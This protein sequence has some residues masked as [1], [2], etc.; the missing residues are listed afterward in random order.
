MN[1]TEGT[2]STNLGST[3]GTARSNSA[4]ISTADQTAITQN[5]IR[6]RT[7]TSDTVLP[8][9]D[10]G[11]YYSPT[12]EDWT[13][14][15]DDE[16][17]EHALNAYHRFPTEQ[18]WAGL[19]EEAR[20]KS[21]TADTKHARDGLDA[22][23]MTEAG[24]EDS[25]QLPNLR[26]YI[27]ADTTTAFEEIVAQLDPDNRDTIAGRQYAQ[28]VVDWQWMCEASEQLRASGQ[29]YRPRFEEAHRPIDW[30]WTA[31]QEDDTK[32][33]TDSPR[34]EP[35]ATTIAPQSQQTLKPVHH[36]NF[37]G[38]P[39]YERTYTAPAVSFWAAKSE[40]L[41]NRVHHNGSL[42]RSVIS[43]N[44]GK[45]LDPFLAPDF[46][47]QLKATKLKDWA[48]GLVEVV[49][50]TYGTW[51]SDKLE[52][53][54]DQRIADGP[55]SFF[56]CGD[57]NHPP[58]P[59]VI[60]PCDGDV[61]INDDGR[62]HLA[63]VS[64]RRACVGLPSK[65][66]QMEKIEDI[67]AV[68]EYLTSASVK[69][70]YTIPPDAFAALFNKNKS[71][72]SINTL[73]SVHEA[74]IETDKADDLP[75]CAEEPL[76]DENDDTSFSAVSDDERLTPPPVHPQDVFDFI[77]DATLDPLLSS[78]ESS[79]DSDHYE[80]SFS[81]LDTNSTGSSVSGGMGESY[82]PENL[83][84]DSVPNIASF[85]QPSRAKINKGICTADAMQLDN[86]ITQAEFNCVRILNEHLAMLP[87]PVP[88]VQQ[89]IIDQP[90]SGTQDVE[91]EDRDFDYQSDDEL[92]IRD[93]DSEDSWS[94]NLEADA[95]VKMHMHESLYDSLISPAEVSIE[96]T[97]QSDKNS[98][99]DYETF[100]K[101][102]HSGCVLMEEEGLEGNLINAASKTENTLTQLQD[103]EG[104]AK[105]SPGS[106]LMLP[107][108]ICSEE[109]MSSVFLVDEAVTITKET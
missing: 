77:K 85:S 29:G 8:A 16:E 59:Y 12:G 46:A 13:S 33:T 76:S 80:S 73:T 53:G 69:N 23:A 3:C 7:S 67:M 87:Q 96:A 26:Q 97:S 66:S 90:F 47:P 63:K 22:E 75:S 83:F 108:H 62:T 1:I 9:S 34:S 45:M 60:G 49:Y 57:V 58:Q 19:D 42:L 91:D 24:F 20:S 44:A 43:S 38:E 31:M 105:L 28:G 40:G 48:T 61:V 18:D 104:G 39:V 5:A 88:Y 100:P 52:P 30:F 68:N 56:G 95:D 78:D 35:R 107:I 4:Q 81:M 14:I 84:S 27:P 102:N 6:S 98:L 106:G 109:T 79:T 89:S 70:S 32:T 11:Y 101:T 36:I 54:D 51:M 15:I 72:V 99:H 37:S 55:C 103:S 10:N 65:L 86:T 21:H 25:F 41:V 71:I 92:E 74:D 17:E 93:S 82:W 94:S 64:K 50:Q 2:H